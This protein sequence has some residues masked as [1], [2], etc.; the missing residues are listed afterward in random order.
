MRLKQNNKEEVYLNAVD[1]NSDALFRHCIIRVSDREVALDLVQDTFTKT[2]EYIMKGNDVDNFR[3]FF[4]RVLNNLIIDHYRKKKDYSLEGLLGD[5]TP[6]EVFDDL[7]SMESETWAEII[8]GEKVLAKV[9]ELPEIYRQ[10]VTMRYVDGFAPQEIAK[11]IDE[12]ENV[13]SVRIYR[14]MKKLKELCQ[15]YE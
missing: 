9:E 7:Q 5:E 15:E 6:P 13:V 12:S 8:D 4:Y 14:G 2:W 1:E 11:M 3:A 10:A